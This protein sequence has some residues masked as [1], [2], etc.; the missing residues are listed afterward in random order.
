MKR[1]LNTVL[2]LVYVS[3]FVAVSL[4]IICRLGLLPNNRYAL[5][6]NLNQRKGKVNVLV[7][8]DSF[9]V[10]TP[11]SASTLLRRHLASRDV[12][13]LNLA[14]GGMG[15]KNY[16]SRLRFYGLR[17]NPQLILVNY[18]VGNDLTDTLY[19]DKAV[20]PVKQWASE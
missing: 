3:V 2:Y 1:L 13:T 10:E 15:P 14:G 20:S 8:G 4:E 12:A 7:L 16:L 9:S 5:N 18:Y 17:Y 11:V 6:A 19:R